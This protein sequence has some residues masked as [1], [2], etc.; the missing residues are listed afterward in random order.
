M[1]GGSLT[2]AANGRC[3][4][5]LTIASHPRPSDTQSGWRYNGHGQK[6]RR[7]TRRARSS[8]LGGQH[9]MSAGRGKVGA[10]KL[11]SVGSPFSGSQNKSIPCELCGELALL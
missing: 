7:W 6:K 1:G 4:R 2:S 11:P 3:Q 5:E 10:L 8:E 9:H